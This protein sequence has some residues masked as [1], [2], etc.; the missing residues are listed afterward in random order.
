MTAEEEV[1]AAWEHVPIDE[2]TDKRGSWKVSNH[3]ASIRI[4]LGC[5]Q[6]DA[7]QAALAFTRQRKREIAEVKEEIAYVDE[8]ICGE[9]HGVE[10]FNCRVGHRILAREQAALDELRIGMGAND[11]QS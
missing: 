10:C 4:G 8:Y 2:C 3:I 7:W 6:P 5:S 11:D 1:R 9:P